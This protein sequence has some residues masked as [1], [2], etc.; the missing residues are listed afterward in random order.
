M[1]PSSILSNIVGFQTLLR[2]C[3]A[4][5]SGSGIDFEKID[6]GFK[7]KHSSPLT[8]AA[9]SSAQKGG[10]VSRIVYDRIMVADIDVRDTYAV[11]YYFI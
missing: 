11:Q 9:Y 5:L 3:K 8:W 2:G 1:A 7:W 6:Y 4:Q 10:A